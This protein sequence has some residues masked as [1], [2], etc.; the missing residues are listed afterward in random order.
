L[1]NFTKITD[2]INS[3]NFRWDRMQTDNIKW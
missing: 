2:L 3:E 1:I